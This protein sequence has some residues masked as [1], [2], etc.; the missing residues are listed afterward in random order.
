MDQYIEGNKA[1][2]EEA[3][4]KRDA[5][6]GADITER[7]QKEDYPF[8]NEE[9][10]SVLK[11]IPTEGA[12]IGQFCCN[13]GRE[14]LSLV[15]SGKAKKGIGFDIAENQ[16][17][18]ANEKAKELRLPC[19]FEAVNIYDIGDRFREQFDV[20]IITIGALCWF[21]DLN[22]FF[23]IVANCMKPGAV[24]VINEE[25]PCKNMLAA[26]GEELY[27]PDHRLECRYSYFEHVWTGNGGMFYI[28][29]KNYLS[30]T[31][32][33]YTHPM[34]EII[35]GMCGSGIVVTGLQEFDHDLTGGFTALD[36][37]GYPLSMIIRG[38]KTAE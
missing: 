29:K 8:F 30:K 13:N 16:V 2:W 27:D 26:E 4:D 21:D 23:A 35:S 37:L 18:F 25:H 38:R 12:V 19:V 24:I 7:I 22:R 3:F 32:T 31:F 36:H 6:W 15:K 1:A 10:K 11:Q 20:V 33:D 5:S 14:L 28:T 17:A 9:T 34:S